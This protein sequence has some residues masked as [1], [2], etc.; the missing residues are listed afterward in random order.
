MRRLSRPSAQSL[1][2]TFVA[3]SIEQLIA[4]GRWNDARTA[5]VQ[6][7]RADPDNHW[8]L[9]RLS[10]T[11][12]EQFDYRRALKLSEQ[13]LGVSPRCP[14]ALW[15]YAGS[16]QMLGR[17]E[18]AAAVYRRLIRRGAEKI[19]T[20]P[21]GEGLS[22]ARGLVADSHFR[23]SA[24][25]RSLGRIGAAVNQF[26]R[27]TDLRV[28]GCATIYSTSVVNEYGRRLLCERPNPAL[29]RAVTR[30]RTVPRARGKYAP[31]S[32]GK[33]R[34]AAAQRKR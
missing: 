28:P 1:G 33:Q 11:Y 22:K 3:R 13:A 7:L 20:D 9:T 17:N 2:R 24:C 12:Y 32:L 34:R 26:R 5:I 6:D 18:E 15:D 29:E 30:R 21:C 31:A 10:L 4:A 23:L 19:A 27:Y 8:L 16:L 14:L 25:Y